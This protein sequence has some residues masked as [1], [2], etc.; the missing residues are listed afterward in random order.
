[1][2]FNPDIPVYGDTS[3]R[4]PCASET[5]EQTTFFN[6]LRRKY[7]D[8]ALIALH[9]RN[10]GKRTYQ[11]AMR[12]KAEGMAAGASD[13]IICGSPTFVCELKRQDH[14]KSKWQDSQED[15]LTT[16]KSYGAF[17]CVALGYK[18]ALEALERWLELQI[19]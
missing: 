1:V 12:H 16:A 3:Y 6:E 18:A 7:P 17:V 9:P 11:Q 8:I 4:G 19:R 2:K 15:F 14:T 13:I 10:E 5:N